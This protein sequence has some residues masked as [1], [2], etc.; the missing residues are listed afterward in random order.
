MVEQNCLWFVERPAQA[1]A[2]LRGCAALS[3]YTNDLSALWGTTGVTLDSS[4]YVKK[5]LWIEDENLQKKGQFVPLEG[6][7]DRLAD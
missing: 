4:K 3:I 2:S 5:T 1:Q 7:K 6:A